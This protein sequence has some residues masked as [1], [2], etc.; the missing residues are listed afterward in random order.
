MSG[1]QAYARLR[2]VG[3][4]VELERQLELAMGEAPAGEY[5]ELYELLETVARSLG[6]G[7]VFPPSPEVLLAR[8]LAREQRESLDRYY[9]P[10]YSK[11]LEDDEAPR[12]R[13]IYQECQ[14]PMVNLQAMAEQLGVKIFWSS[15]PFAAACGEY[16]G[17]PRI[18]WARQTVARLFMNAVRGFNAIG[19]AP[20][21]EDGYR[22][23]AVQAGLF[24]AR[25]QAVRQ[26]YPFLSDEEVLREARAK[27]ACA[28]YHAAH[29]GGAAIDFTLRDFEGQPLDLGNPYPTGGAATV[30]CFPY[31]TWQQFR[32]RQLFACISTMAGLAPY[33]GEDWHVSY[34]DSLAALNH[35]ESVVRFGPLR[36]FDRSSGAVIP[37]E[38]ADA[39]ISFPSE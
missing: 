34:G 27:T 9:L 15:R 30:L 14:E 7:A 23:P 20:Y 4:N 39:R 28:P 18:Y 2:A 17:K 33:P 38:Y 21:V 26:G 22:P 13:M 12:E 37:Y 10:L 1:N 5:A 36:D 6:A 11:A 32:T 24:R 29:M 35:G 19:L 31:V 16:A 3:R 8:E 25:V